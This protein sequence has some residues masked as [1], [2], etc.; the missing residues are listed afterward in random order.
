MAVC[1]AETSPQTG[2]ATPFYISR[3]D[4]CGDVS[5]RCKRNERAKRAHS[6]YH[7][8]KI[9]NVCLSVTEAVTGN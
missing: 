8:Y 7:I 4:E 1:M 2:H 9:T 3:S 6:L 5:S